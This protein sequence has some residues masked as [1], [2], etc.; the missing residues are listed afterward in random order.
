VRDPDRDRPGRARHQRI[1]PHGRRPRHRRPPAPPSR[2]PPRHRPQSPA[3]PI[4]VLRAPPPCCATPDSC[5]A[6]WPAPK[7]LSSTPEAGPGATQLPPGP[8]APR[9]CHSGWSSRPTGT[10]KSGPK[11]QCRAQSSSVM[12]C[13]RKLDHRAEWGN[14]GQTRF[15]SGC[16]RRDRSSR[17]TTMLLMA[18][19]AR[20]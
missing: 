19:M 8:S 3:P 4:A 9:W 6:T 13:D 12:A 11:L 5:R 20:F 7:P 16:S 17:A 2:S 14:C 18:G 15:A 1:V 10:A